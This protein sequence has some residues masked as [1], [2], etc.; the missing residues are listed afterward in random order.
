MNPRCRAILLF[1]SSNSQINFDLNFFFVFFFLLFLS[2]KESELGTLFLIKKKEK[3]ANKIQVKIFSENLKKNKAK[4]PDNRGSTGSLTTSTTHPNKIKRRQEV[5]DHYVF[6]LKRENL[7]TKPRKCCQLSRVCMKLYPLVF[8]CMK[9]NV[10]GFFSI[11][12]LV[13]LFFLG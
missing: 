4:Q 9:Y 1:F 11:W 2:E 13:L 3:K 5:S 10:L 6:N 8:L 12:S 7:I